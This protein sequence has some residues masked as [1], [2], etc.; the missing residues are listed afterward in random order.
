MQPGQAPFLNL[1]PFQC[2]C[3][4]ENIAKVKINGESCQDLLD[5]GAQVNTITPDCVRGHSLGRGP[6]ADLVSMGIACVDLVNVYAHPLGG[7]IVWVQ[8]DGVQGYDKDQMAL[9]I[10]VESK[11]ADQ[12]PVIFGTL[13]ISHIV[14]VMKKKETDALAMPWADARVAHLLSMH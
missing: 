9:V 7:V 1:D 13:T 4:V 5:S 3:R 8:V 12:V 10:P 6:V 14:N 2:W 11:F